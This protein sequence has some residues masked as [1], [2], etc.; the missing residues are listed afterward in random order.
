MSCSKP[1]K[2]THILFVFRK[3]LLPIV[4]TIGVFGNGAT[5][6]KS[7]SLSLSPFMHILKAS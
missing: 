2:H 5:I 3:V 7:I 4:G 1:S 6:R